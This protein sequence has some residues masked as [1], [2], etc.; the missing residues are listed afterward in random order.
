MPPF[1]YIPPLCPFGRLMRR[2]L[3]PTPRLPPPRLRRV[4]S[5]G[6]PLV[7]MLTAP[8]EPNILTEPDMW[9]GVP[10]SI[11]ARIFSYPGDRHVPTFGEFLSVDYLDDG[12]RTDTFFECK[13]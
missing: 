6:E 4:S 13:R 1:L 12:V 2:I 11:R 7:E 5:A 10:R 9:D 8:L 3:T